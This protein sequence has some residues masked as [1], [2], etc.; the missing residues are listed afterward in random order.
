[1]LR[2]KNY[3]GTDL[4]ELAVQ[5]NREEIMKDLYT[6]DVERLISQEVHAEM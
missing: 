3:K 1:M 5:Q 6:V 4:V 2:L